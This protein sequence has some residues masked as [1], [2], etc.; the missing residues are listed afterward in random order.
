MFIYV[1][2]NH[3]YV[4]V[5]SHSSKYT[6]S[7]LFFI[8]I[9]PLFQRRHNKKLFY[10][11]YFQICCPGT[12]FLSSGVEIISLNISK[13]LCEMVIVIP[14]LRWRNSTSETPL[15]QTMQA[16]GSTVQANCNTAHS[17]YDSGCLGYLHANLG[18]PPCTISNMSGKLLNVCLSTYRE[19]SL[20]SRL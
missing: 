5:K 4:F 12:I 11:Y 10:Y 7:V 13:H 14:T 2:C 1:L 17:I 6:R 20:F 9:L 18:F 19:E 8:C 15:S 3:V 16:V